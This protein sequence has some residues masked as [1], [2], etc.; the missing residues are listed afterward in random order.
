MLLSAQCRHWF[1]L[2]VSAW[3]LVQ[4][5]YWLS[6][7]SFFTFKLSI[8]N[9]RITERLFINYTQCLLIMVARENEGYNVITFKC[10]IRTKTTPAKTWKNHTTG[11]V[12]NACCIIHSILGVFLKNF[13]QVQVWLLEEIMGLFQGN[14]TYCFTPSYSPLAPLDY[15][16]AVSIMF[17]NPTSQHMYRTFVTTTYKQ[18]QKHFVIRKNKYLQA[19]ETLHALR[20]LLCSFYCLPREL[21]SFHASWWKER[22]SVVV[23]VKKKTS[24]KFE[25]LCYDFYQLFSFWWELK[26]VTQSL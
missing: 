2:V 18:C 10:F 4:W 11:N 8:N 3:I 26:L 22:L 9:K 17:H 23:C 15:M 14:L 7:W 12:L 5:I 25:K 1:I 13:W 16:N 19:L 20:Y 6:F 21:N 24:F